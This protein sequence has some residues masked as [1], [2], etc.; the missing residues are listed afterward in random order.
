MVIPLFLLVAALP[1]APEFLPLL[2]IGSIDGSCADLKV[3]PLDST[4]ECYARERL[5]EPADWPAVHPGAADVWAGSRPYT[6]RF[7]FTPAAQGPDASGTYRL[8]IGFLG[9]HPYSPP[10]LRVQVGDRVW[11]EQSLE[12]GKQ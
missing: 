9:A 4:I 1:A 12:P 5:I 3:L 6:Y 2:R 7:A 10:T 8:R 11:S